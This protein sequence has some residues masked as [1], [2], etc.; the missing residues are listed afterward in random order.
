MKAKRLT[1]YRLSDKARV[2]LKA[3]SDDS[4]LTQTAVLEV[5]IRE[6]AKR[7]KMDFDALIGEYGYLLCKTE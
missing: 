7:R 6:E 3:L 1:T 4:S 5:L 2:F